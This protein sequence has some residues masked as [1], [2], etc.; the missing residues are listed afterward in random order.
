[1]NRGYFL[2]RC[3]MKAPLLIGCDITNLSND[4]LMILT[5]EEAIAVNQGKHSLNTRTHARIYKSVVQSVDK[6]RCL[7]IELFTTHFYSSDTL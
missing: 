7:L 2:L 3:L 1:M 5:N 6:T 4:T